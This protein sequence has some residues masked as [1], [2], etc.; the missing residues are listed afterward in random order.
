MAIEQ[1]LLQ[2][3]PMNEDGLAMIREQRSQYQQRFITSSA[4]GLLTGPV[5]APGFLLFGVAFKAA[6]AIS[7]CTQIEEVL[8]ILL[9]EF[10]EMS[11]KSKKESVYQLNIDLFNWLSD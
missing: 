6:S 3:P 2:V 9:K 10:K 1:N 5:V 7:K 4:G 8:S 11:D